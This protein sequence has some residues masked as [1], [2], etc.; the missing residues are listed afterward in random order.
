MKKLLQTLVLTAFVALASPA[1][2]LGLG[3]LKLKSGPNQPLVADIPVISND[4]AELDRLQARLAAP[5]TFL[6][7]G[8]PLPDKMVSDLR[9]SLVRDSDG[10]PVIRVT[11]PGPVA[12]PMLTFLL[13]VDW[14]EGRLVREYSVLVAAPESV[15][16]AAVPDI[17]AAEG[18]PS[19]TIVRDGE[20]GISQAPLPEAGQTAA[21][22][23]ETS[24]TVATP[25]AAGQTLPAVQRGQTLSGIAAALKQPG[26]D[27]QTVMAA[28]LL[29]NPQAFI[30]GNPNRLREGAVL[31]LPAADAANGGFS[32]A[33]VEAM[34]AQLA[35]W[36]SRSGR[37]GRAVNVASAVSD[38][39]AARGNHSNQANTRRS[40]RLEIAPAAASAGAAATRSGTGGKGDSSMAQQLQEA[41]ETIAARDAEVAELKSRVAELENLK[42]QQ[43]QLIQMKDGELAL[44]QQ[45]LKAQAEV[46]AAQQDSTGSTLLWS[47]LAV[48]LLAGIVFAA[49]IL[50]Q[51]KQTSWKATG[52]NKR[53]DMD[54]IAVAKPLADDF[55]PVFEPEMPEESAVE[56]ASEQSF[57]AGET[58]A[59][60]DFQNG[61]DS[62]DSVATETASPSAAANPLWHLPSW[63]GSASHDWE[64]TGETKDD[65]AL[66]P[67]TDDPAKI[68]AWT[69]PADGGEPRAEGFAN[70]AQP[71]LPDAVPAVPLQDA[72]SADSIARPVGQADA[73]GEFEDGRLMLART[74][75]ELGDHGTARLLLQQVLDDADGNHANEARQLL[76][77]LG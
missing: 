6:R 51:R 52:K 48:L 10:K 3:Q 63:V 65:V 67:L 34:A 42:E 32:T 1:W 36:R 47:A 22:A 15:E 18:A 62:G 70:Q 68:G 66:K 76:E 37:R 61:G 30:H 43:N 77:S 19:N 71:V 31:Q 39:P 27:L 13:E 14:G 9:F 17:N 49:W 53:R 24:A 8:L 2:A 25:A 46:R 40:A 54:S 64:K 57:A 74:Y 45:Q 60:D 72:F 29:A 21:G 75:I 26:Q 56:A 11:S 35:Q 5:E 12:I 16:A 38:A 4:P 33:E 55:E 58:A 44:A 50:R 73:E 69:F 7:V 23:A 20:G 41:Q 28:L 59:W